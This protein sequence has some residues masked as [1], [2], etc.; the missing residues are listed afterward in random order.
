[1]SHG[2]RGETT[3]MAA[4]L[5]AT[6][7]GPLGIA[8][9]TMHALD[10]L[11]PVP[12]PR[13]LEF[14]DPKVIDKWR[15]GGSIPDALQPEFKG[16]LAHTEERITAL[17]ENERRLRT[18]LWAHAELEK[19]GKRDFAQLLARF[20]RENWRIA[21]VSGDIAERETQIKNLIAAKA[22]GI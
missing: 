21:A 15:I 16:W 4:M 8:M 3:P 17:S 14:S 9:S 1:M 19:H 6:R 12:V 22:R 18:T 13:R 10:S 5:A 11:K 2:E 7:G 20:H